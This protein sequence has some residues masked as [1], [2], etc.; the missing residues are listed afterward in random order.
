MAYM[1]RCNMKLGAP[2]TVSLP[3]AN[4]TQHLCI[5][6]YKALVHYITSNYGQF[7]IKLRSYKRQAEGMDH[8]HIRTYL[9]LLVV[10]F[11]F[12]AM[13]IIN[14]VFSLAYF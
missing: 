5:I 4:T 2:P 7:H 14:M 3:Q 9:Y 6:Y 1:Y 13:V 10:N 11:Y 12:H 8:V